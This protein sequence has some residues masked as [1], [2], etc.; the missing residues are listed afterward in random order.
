MADVCAKVRHAVDDEHRAPR[1]PHKLAR[2]GRPV[3]RPVFSA[4]EDRDHDEEGRGKADKRKAKVECQ[5]PGILGF[6]DSPGAHSCLQEE[7]ADHQADQD[8][9]V[10]PARPESQRD[11]SSCQDQN[12]FDPGHE[13]VTEL[14]RGFDGVGRDELAVTERPVVAAPFLGAGIGHRRAHHHDEE[15]SNRGQDRYFSNRRF[16]WSTPLRDSIWFLMQSSYYWRPGYKGMVRGAAQ[17][18][19]LRSLAHATNKR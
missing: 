6:F 18:P 19:V 9:D 11:V 12:A 14:D 16:Y 10:P 1:E 2:H 17:N 5:Y 3:N 4:V 7:R 8:L 13:S 15:H